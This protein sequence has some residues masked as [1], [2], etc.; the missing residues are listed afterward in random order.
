MK[1]HEKHLSLRPFAFDMTGDS[2]VGYT[3]PNILADH[4][5]G[6]VVIT[7]LVFAP[8]MIDTHPSVYW[9]QEFVVVHV[10]YLKEFFRWNTVT[11]ETVVND[12]VRQA[13]LFQLTLSRF[14]KDA[15]DRILT[16]EVIV[17]TFWHF[18]PSSFSR[19]H[20]SLVARNFVAT[21]ISSM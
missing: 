15:V 13:R 18:V 4:R 9:F 10:S 1:G 17:C 20:P 19:D 6:L 12:F 8:Q 11:V 2:S 5:M 14:V 16:K 21:K 7:I 3:F